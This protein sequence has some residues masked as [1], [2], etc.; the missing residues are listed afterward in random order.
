MSHAKGGESALELRTGVAVIRHGIMAK[1]AEPI[2]I[3]HQRQGRAGGTDAG[4]AINENATVYPLKTAKNPKTLDN[5]LAIGANVS[6]I[7]AVRVGKAV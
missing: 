7:T 3:D 2:G 6:D 1:K 5:L 4:S